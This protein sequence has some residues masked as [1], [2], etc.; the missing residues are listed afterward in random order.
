VR[1]PYI[2]YRRKAGKKKADCYYVAFYDKKSR[3]Y[4]LRRSAKTLKE[5]LGDRARHLSFSSR[6]AAEEMARM[7]MALHLDVP[8]DRSLAT[9]PYLESFW[10]P[11]GSYATQK[12]RTGRPLSRDYMIN[13]RSAIKVHAIPWLKSTNNEKTP[14][15]H[16]T[17]G[18]IEDMLNDMFESGTSAKRC[19]EVR[20]AMSKAF[21]ELKR[22]G[23][24]SSNPVADTYRFREDTAKRQILT[25]GEAQKFFQKE[26]LDDRARVAC[27]LAMT[28]GVRISE[29]LGLQ[30]EDLQSEIISVDG[31]DREYWWIQL[32]HA[33]TEAERL[34]APKRDSRGD[35]PIPA[36]VA[37]E[38]LDLHAMNPWQDSY[39]FYGDTR[40]RPVNARK[41]RKEYQRVLME[42]E[43]DPDVQAKRGIDD[44]HAWR[45]FYASYVKGSAT[46]VLRHA[47][48][49]TTERYTHMTGEERRAIAD[50]AT[51]LIP[52]GETA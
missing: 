37:R 13:S 24:I 40:G 46:K 16:V 22:K 43:I 36:K 7:A 31:D 33:W 21:S 49:E 38:L 42:I 10:D 39:V 30:R 18:M 19:N 41:I 12:S 34:H 26:F 47:D 32:T 11:D 25:P 20:K 23:V 3:K 5:M 48:A 1:K 15:Q 4:N 2:V 44:F 51:A 29:V 27:L 52:Q 35:V 28:S 9:G 50:Q 14:V 6:A 45:H 17:T 8:S